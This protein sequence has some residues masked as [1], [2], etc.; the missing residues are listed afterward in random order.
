MENNFENI[1]KKFSEASKASDEKLNTPE[2]EN[3]WNKIEE[4]LDKKETKKRILPIW[5][6]YGIAA[7]LLIG[8]GVYFF[9]S[10]NSVELVK[11][12]I[13]IN[14]NL[15]VEKPIEN[16]EIR[17]IDE[18][19]KSNIAKEKATEKTEVIAMQVP[20]PT[21]SPKIIGNSSPKEN[22]VYNEN[23]KYFTDEFLVPK[24]STNNLEEVAITAYEAKKKQA[25]LAETSKMAN[26]E[27][28]AKISY[29][30]C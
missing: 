17:K 16:P 27:S 25:E 12:K 19:I 20:T 8:S 9:N 18:T 11:P 3:I 13:T 24:K 15:P 26:S 1:D 5:L 23:G 22:V 28:R 29:S 2:F 6:P 4:K 10:K 14:K 21:K 30:Q 7:S